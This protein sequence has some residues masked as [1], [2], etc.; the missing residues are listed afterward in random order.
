MSITQA[1]PKPQVQSWP[2]AGLRAVTVNLTA[3]QTLTMDANRAPDGNLNVTAGTFD[4]STFTIN[5]S[6][7]GGALTVSNGATLRIGGTNSFPANYNTHTIGAT[8]TVSA[9]DRSGSVVVQNSGGTTYGHLIIS[10]SGT[11]TLAGTETVAG[12][13]TINGG[14]FDLTTFTISRSSAGGTLTV[15]DGATLKIGGT[16]TIPANYSAHA[17]GATSTIEFAGTAQSIP[18]LNSS[19]SYGHLT[20]SGSGNKTL[21]A[22]IS[23]RGNWTNN[24]GTIVPGAGIVTF[25]GTTT[26]T[27]SGNVTPFNNLTI[28]TNAIVV[29][30]AT[31]IP[32][33]A[34]TM[35]NNGTLQQTLN[36]D[37][38]APVSFLTISTDKYRGVDIDTTGTGANLGAVTVTVRSTAVFDCPNAGGVTP[39]YARRCFDIT[40][41]NQGAAAVTLWVLNSELGAI[42]SDRLCRTALQEDR[43]AI[44]TISRK[45]LPQDFLASWLDR[46]VLPPQRLR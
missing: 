30:P 15:A 12:N 25:N 34:G 1:M 2:V 44:T 14:T 28:N 8:S 38:S 42:P 27:I 26:Q 33:V 19:Q 6:G 11:K 46:R 4:L 17:I 35:T 45:A 5:R 21:A 7:A 10:G 16:N 29:I 36:V 37:N 20:T 18:V 39:I 41:T 3:G 24:G 22:A 13:L 32:T 23:V 31:N 40:P 9:L 43:T